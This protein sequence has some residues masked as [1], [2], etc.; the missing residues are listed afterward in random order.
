MWQ[1]IAKQVGCNAKR[2]YDS[3]VIENT[4]KYAYE[5]IN[6]QKEIGRHKRITRPT[7][8]TNCCKKHNGGK[9]SEEYLFV[10]K[11]IK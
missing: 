5:C 9:F 10:Q 2:C 4:F 3:N 8:C 11:L 1:H 7:A 6:C